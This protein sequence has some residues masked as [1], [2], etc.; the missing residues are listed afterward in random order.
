VFVMYKYQR[1]KVQATY[2]PVKSSTI[3]IYVLDNETR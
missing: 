2:M 1:Q 3:Y